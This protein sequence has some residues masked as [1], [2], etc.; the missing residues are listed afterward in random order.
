MDDDDEY[1]LGVV[2]V[3]VVVDVVVVVV[4]DEIMNVGF[5]ILTGILVIDGFRSIE[6]VEFGD[7]T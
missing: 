4:D 6:Y 1:S 2:A 5:E 7:E 3:V